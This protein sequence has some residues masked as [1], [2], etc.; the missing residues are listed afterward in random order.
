[1]AHS[2]LGFKKHSKDSEEE[3]HHPLPEPPPSY[4]EVQGYPP[5]DVHAI[6]SEVKSDSSAYPPQPHHTQA[7]SRLMNVVYEHYRTDRIRVLDADNTNTLYTMKLQM[8][9]P[10]IVVKATST[11][12][13]IGTANLH[14]FKGGI[15]TT[16]HDNSITLSKHGFFKSTYT[17][18]SPALEGATLTW[19]FK[20]LGVEI[21]CLDER[22][23]AIARFRFNN[24]SAKKCGTL[25]ML[26]PQ[27]DGGLL[28]DEILVTGL[29]VVEV[30]LTIRN[31]SRGVGAVG[32]SGAG[33]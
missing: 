30:I 32:A 21:L 12:T 15:D 7:P 9:K 16:V 10:H 14:M 29:A 26:G 11:E 19:K 31:A 2:L 5:Q 24:W 27:A 18:P 33:C 23:I 3:A 13:T 6:E 25:E 17:W 20:N 1:M 8:K 28:M 22:E 4:P